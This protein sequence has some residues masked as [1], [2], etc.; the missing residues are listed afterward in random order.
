MEEFI[1]AVPPPDSDQELNQPDIQVVTESRPSTTLRRGRDMVTCPPAKGFS[2]IPGTPWEQQVRSEEHLNE[3]LRGS[4]PGEVKPFD[5][6]KA[7]S[8]AAG[9][10]AALKASSDK[11]AADA[12]LLQQMLRD[13]GSVTLDEGRMVLQRVTSEASVTDAGLDTQVFGAILAELPR[14]NASQLKVLSAAASALIGSDAASCKPQVSPPR[15]V[16]N[17]RGRGLVPTINCTS[18]ASGGSH[19][20]KDRSRSTK[21]RAGPT[22]GGIRTNGSGGRI[23]YDNRI[24]I[25]PKGKKFRL[26]A[27]RTRT[28]DRL[29]AE[30]ELQTVIRRLKQ[31]SDANRISVDNPPGRDT[32]LGQR[33]YVLMDQFTVSKANLKEIKAR[34]KPK[35]ASQ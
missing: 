16:P 6:T 25:T 15:G 22:T 26:Q 29:K 1:P 19:A 17:N 18:S 3:M 4:Y 11:A 10:A 23:D 21:I 33:Y 28:P 30:A 13:I 31:F 20:V 14:M 8:C 34:E 35:P 12:E 32:E 27:P 2:R 7:A 9:K 24:Y 5:L